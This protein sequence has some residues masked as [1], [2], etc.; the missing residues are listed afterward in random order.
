MGQTLE[1]LN[2]E[3]ADANGKKSWSGVHKD[4]ALPLP[5]RGV[6]EVAQWLRAM[7][8]LTV[9]SDLIASTLWWLRTVCNSSS[10][11]SGTLSRPP[12][13]YS[14]HMVH[15]DASITSVQTKSNKTRRKQVRPGQSLLLPGASPLESKEQQHCRV[16]KHDF[17]W[18]LQVA[19]VSLQ[20]TKILLP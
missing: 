4:W 17:T 5:R 9:N 13:A 15:T 16:Q 11:V 19:Q 2:R 1:E 14:T 18:N 10:R 6:G 3:G 7:A 12:Q 8:A 20:L